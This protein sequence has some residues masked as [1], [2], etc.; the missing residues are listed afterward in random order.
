MS[1]VQQ[2]IKEKKKL[3]E[4]AA[5]LDEQ[6]KEAALASFTPQ[7]AQVVAMAGE[8]AAFDREVKKHVKSLVAAVFGDDFAVQK[9]KSSAKTSQTFDWKELA[10]T[11]KSN[12]ITSKAKAK[13]KSEIA[14]L[15]FG[16][17]DIEFGAKWNDKD[18]RAKVLG[19]SGN[20]R[21]AGYWAK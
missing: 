9:K 2:L 11:L 6:I 8:L 21:S 7:L 19:T 10:K 20:L 17:E 13:S 5:K 15:Y 18:E 14:R 4:A 12:G 3:E 16:N 1:T